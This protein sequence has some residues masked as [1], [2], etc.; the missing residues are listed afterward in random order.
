MEASSVHFGGAA[1]SA[2]MLRLDPSI[3]RNPH[4]VGGLTGCCLDAET[5]ARVEPEHDVERAATGQK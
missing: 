2:V 1:P 4:R 5:D 3:A